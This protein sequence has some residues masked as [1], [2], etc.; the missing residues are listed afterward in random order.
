MD[1]TELLL[2][3]PASRTRLKMG[4]GGDDRC[5]R[6]PNKGGWVR[7]TTARPDRGPGA[8]GTRHVRLRSSA[9]RGRWQ[10]LPRPPQPQR[11]PLGCAAGVFFCPREPA[12]PAGHLAGA[13]SGA[14]LLPPFTHPGPHPRLPLG[15]QAAW[16]SQRTLGGSEERVCLTS[17]SKSPA[18]LCSRAAF[19]LQGGG[20]SSSGQAPGLSRACSPQ[21][22][23]ARGPQ[24]GDR[25]PAQKGPR[26]CQVAPRPLLSAQT[27]TPPWDALQAPG[28]H[29]QQP[30]PGP[31]RVPLSP[32]PRAGCPW[33]GAP[34]ARRPLLAPPLRGVQT[35]PLGAPAVWVCGGG[36][37]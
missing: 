17:S 32:L 29:R 9:A 25:K 20:E 23:L 7:P 35:A 14:P 24:A 27:C 19:L 12:P 30:P 33:H 15:S 4:K 31:D 13:L 37:W 26:Q 2:L 28:L 3:S 36:L 6:G 16:G 22:P 5:V 1:L 21:I 18:P 11:L 8:C 34:W 10:P